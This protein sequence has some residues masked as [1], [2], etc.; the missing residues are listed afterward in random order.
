[1][2]EKLGNVAGR[3]KDAGADG[4]A[5]RRGHAKPHAKN[6]EQAT[7][8]DRVRRANCGRGFR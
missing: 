3:V 8:A 4:V 6:L 7:A 2:R 5:D 1:V